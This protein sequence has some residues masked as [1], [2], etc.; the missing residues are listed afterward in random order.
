MRSLPDVNVLIALAFSA[1]GS[2][3]AAHVWFEQEPD[4]LWATC[5]LTQ[6]GFLRVAG[7]AIGGTRDA[8]GR[9]LAGLQRDCSRPGHE[10]WPVDA[11]LRE[12]SE[13]S[14]LRLIGA[15]QVTD[16]QLLLLAHKHRGQLVTFDGGLRQLASGTKYADSVV[17]L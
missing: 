15:N 3:A 17:I 16:M 8:I 2:H 1:H 7:R 6:G 10:Y 5:A 11:D 14:R 9:A 4:R 13:Y 12:L